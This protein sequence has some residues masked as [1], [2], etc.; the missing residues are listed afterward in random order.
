MTLVNEQQNQQKLVI[1]FNFDF[2]LF[3]PTRFEL[4]LVVMSCDVIFPIRF[5]YRPFYFVDVYR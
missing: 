1:I 4:G 3:F 5:L 2:V